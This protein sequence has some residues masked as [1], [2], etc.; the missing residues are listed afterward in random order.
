MASE[1]IKAF[2]GITNVRPSKKGDEQD[3]LTHVQEFLF[4]F[5]YIKEKESLK[6]G[7]LDE[8]TSV[9][10]AKYQT[11]QGLPDTGEFD[12]TIR[13]QM[14]T[15]RCAFP[16]MSAGVEFAI[17]CDWEKAELTY[18]FDTGTGDVTGRN[19]FQATRNAFQTWAE[20][21][22]LTFREVGIGE[23]PDV[24]IAWK[25][26]NDPDLSM[27]GGTLAHADFPPGCGVV[28]D[29][30]PKPVHFDDTEHTWAIGAVPGA[31]DVESVALHEIGHILGLAH[32][33]VGGSIM[34]PSIGSNRTNRVLT[35]DDISRVQ[36][37]YS[38]PPPATVPCPDVVGMSQSQARQ[39]LTQAGLEIGD[40]T[41]T[42]AWWW[43][44][45]GWLIG[46]SRVLSQ[47][48]VAGASVATG[49]AV[50]LFIRKGP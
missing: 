5:G 45:L 34:F 11:C 39:T 13:S 42:R 10:L 50:A 27:V 14:T 20:V 9:A 36:N 26:A 6:S 19:E 48:P 38:T 41:T 46:G 44:L 28:T 32:T 2:V 15:D 7:C 8:E 35:Q 3:G 40:V 47:N 31:F 4:R 22:P 37:L 49:N 29:T 43:W 16:D 18:A 23:S 1:R 33:N 25:P 21:I 24:L 17:T 30:L 12:E